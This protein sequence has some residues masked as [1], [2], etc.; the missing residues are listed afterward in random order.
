M[1][2]LRL[3]MNLGIGYKIYDIAFGEKIGK[4]IFSK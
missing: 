4:R 2:C 1:S 3:K